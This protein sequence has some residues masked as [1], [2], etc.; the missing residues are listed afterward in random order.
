MTDSDFALFPQAASS[1][2]GDVDRLFW[3]LTGMTA[4]L[5]VLIAGTIV[6]FG[7][8]YRRASSI[9]RA[10]YR[11]PLWLEVSWIV[12]PMPVLIVIFVWSSSLYLEMQTPP[13]DAM[14]INVVAKQWMWKFQHPSGRREIDELHIPQGRPI[15]MRMISEDVIH[16][17]FVPAFRVKQDVL[18]GRYTTV[19]FNATERGSYHLFCA[20]YCG[21]NHSRMVGRVIVVTPT[22]YQNWLA[23]GSVD[24]APASAG[25]D[26]FVQLRCASCHAGGGTRSPGP[27]LHGLAGSMVTLANGAQVTAD[28]AYLRESILRPNAKV[29]AG[30]PPAMPTFEG[31]LSEEALLDLV[32]YIKSLKAPEGAQQ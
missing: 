11:P 13:T 18:P 29:V 26:L 27:S 10:A 32:A 20:E 8:R 3:F 7:V 28:D 14:Q 22:D 15:L 2:A 25:A 5:T 12:A 31:Q 21:T 24:V 30:F 17:F 4:A 1:V 6:Y 16:S 19:W 23:G 9:N